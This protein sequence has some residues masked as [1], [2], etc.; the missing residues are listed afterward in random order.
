MNL[1]LE[2]SSEARAKLT[3]L[4]MNRNIMPMKKDEMT[5][6]FIGNNA[7]VDFTNSQ[8]LLRRP[9]YAPM[10]SA[11][12][13]LIWLAQAGYSVNVKDLEAN[14]DKVTELRS[15]LRALF[16]ACIDGKSIESEH[17]SL[18]NKYL[19]LY[20]EK[21]E[22]SLE[23]GQFVLNTPPRELSVDELLGLLSHDAA[24]LLSSDKINKLKRC[25][26]DKCILVYVDKSKSG[27]RKWCSMDICGNRT[28]SANHYHSTKQSKKL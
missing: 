23:D 5:F 20:F 28:K 2:L 26:H 4:S 11:D 25:S 22:L 1:L 9:F 21:K 17:L 12:E 16:A 6:Q 10:E 19:P 15:G 24:K 8:V 3:N 7:A 14:L 18:L 27:Q 13:V